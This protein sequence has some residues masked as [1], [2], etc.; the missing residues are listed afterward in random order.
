MNEPYNK[1]IIPITEIAIFQFK[2]NGQELESFNRGRF[3]CIFYLFPNLTPT[4]VI[5][6]RIHVVLLTKKGALSHSLVDVNSAE[7]CMHGGK[8]SVI[9]DLTREK[10]W[11]ACSSNMITVVCSDQ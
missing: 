10:R 5:H 3:R 4:T 7:L 6:V 11:L 1:Q 8:F 2:L 9:K